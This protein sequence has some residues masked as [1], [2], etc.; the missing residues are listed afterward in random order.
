MEYRYHEGYTHD[1]F[2]LLQETQLAYIT[3][4]HSTTG[5]TPSLIERCWKPLF[6]VDHLKNNLLQI[7]PTEK[8]FNDM[9]KKTCDT[10][11]IFLAKAKEYNKQRYD[12]PHKEPDF[13]EV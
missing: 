13:R 5:K 10:D 9:W 1:W 11:A 7:L 3:I 6:P 4:Q 2:T 12:N 8:E